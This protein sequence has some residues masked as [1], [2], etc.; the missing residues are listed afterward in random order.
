MKFLLRFLKYMKISYI[1]IR[2]LLVCGQTRVRRTAWMK[3]QTSI[4]SHGSFHKS[5][6]LVI[7]FHAWWISVW[8]TIS[9]L[10]VSFRFGNLC[11]IGRLRAILWLIIDRSAMKLLSFGFSRCQKHKSWN[12]LPIPEPIRG[13]LQ[14]STPIFHNRIGSSNRRPSLYKT[15]W[16]F[17]TFL[18][19]LPIVYR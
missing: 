5:K 16:T 9:R 4:V 18:T 13:L 1:L 11:A 10:R 3:N 14:P 17:F 7:T 8:E 19:L 6:I 2:A 12:F 15:A